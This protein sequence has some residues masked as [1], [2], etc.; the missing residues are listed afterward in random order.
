MTSCAAM[1]SKTIYKSDTTIDFEKIGFSQLY[2][3]KELNKIYP[4]TD[5]IFY[6]AIND[7]YQRNL[8]NGIQFLDSGIDFNV[9]DKSKVISLC[10]QHNLN[11]IIIPH[12]KVIGVSQTMMFI[13]IGKYVDTEVELK[14]YDKTGELI[15]HTK[16]N[17]A[18]GNSY[19]TYPTTDMTITDGA[20]GAIKKM[21]KEYNLLRV[22]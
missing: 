11:G 15:I 21:L 12:L 7:L 18:N 1:G 19:G 2:Y 13:P 4:S 9:T 6:S 10:E 3:H 16:H 5:S 14:L 8:N 22:K 17:T 20:E